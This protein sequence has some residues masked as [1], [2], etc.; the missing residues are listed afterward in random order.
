MYDTAFLRLLGEDFRVAEQSLAES[1]T[2]FNRRAYLRLLGVM[3]ESFTHFLRETL[4]Q[5][6]ANQTLTP[7][8]EVVV[9]LREQS[10]SLTSR[11]EPA[12]RRTYPPTIENL[13]FVLTT[14]TRTEI[15]GYTVNTSHP[16]FHAFRSTFEVRN[17]VTHPKCATDLQ[18]SNAELREARAA[19]AWF[20]AVTHE[21]IELL[22]EADSVA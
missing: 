8:A 9:L 7:P 19:H 4:L 10:Y 3:V 5:R 14:D 21:S 11:G 6:V 17:R 13:L 15:E 12:G 18:V 22:I 16:A 2:A 20:E 1:D